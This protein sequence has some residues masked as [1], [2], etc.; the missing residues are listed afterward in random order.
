MHATARTRE[1][2]IARDAAEQRRA[3]WQRAASCW[4][5]GTRVLVPW[6][7]PRPG[8]TWVDLADELIEAARDLFGE[9]GAAAARDWIGGSGEAPP[10]HLWR[11]IREG[12]VARLRPRWLA[13]EVFCVDARRA[14]AVLLERPP[15]GL[16][17]ADTDVEPDHARLR[18]RTDRGDHGEPVD[19]LLR[20][21]SGEHRDVQR[22]AAAFLLVA[23]VPPDRKRLDGRDGE[24]AAFRRA[25]AF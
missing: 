1:D 7:E 8:E 15:S 23:P 22:T 11:Q 19:D 5:Q 16:T 14:C 25:F 20:R 17:S 10:W 3:T 18:R 9:D 6:T 4:G 13:G 24:L 2:I 12:A 21:L